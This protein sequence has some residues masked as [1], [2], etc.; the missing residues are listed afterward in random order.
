[1]PHIE[2]GV[3]LNPKRQDLGTFLKGITGQNVVNS[4]PGL[5][6]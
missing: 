3:A 2:K 4:L 6:V 1:V 5:I